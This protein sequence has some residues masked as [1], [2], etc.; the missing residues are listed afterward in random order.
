MTVRVDG[1][2][3]VPMRDGY[4]YSHTYDGRCVVL[5]GPRDRMMDLCTRVRNSQQ[6][7]GPNVYV[8]AFDFPAYGFLSAN[9]CPLHAHAVA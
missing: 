3:V 2:V 4:A 1:V 9:E 8:D 5:S 6:T 7:G